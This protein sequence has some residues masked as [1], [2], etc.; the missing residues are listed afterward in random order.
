[1]ILLNSAVSAAIS[2][3]MDAYLSGSIISDFAVAHYSIFA[4]LADAKITNG[5]A[6]EFLREAK[7]RGADE[8]SNIYYNNFVDYSAEYPVT[9]PQVY[10]VGERELAF[11]SSVDYEKLRSGNYVIVSNDVI[12][13][14][15]NAVTVPQAGDTLT[16]T[17][18]N[19]ITQ[20]FEVYDSVDRYPFHLS[21]R[22]RFANCLTV[23]M[24][25]EVFSDFY[26]GTEPMQTNINVSAENISDFEIWLDGYTANQ[27]PDLDFISRNTLKTEFDGLRTTYLAL[28]GAMSLILAL[29]GV[30]NFI[31][32]VVASITARRRELAMLQSVGMTGKQTR[33]MLFSEGICY[34]ALTVVFTLTAGLGIGRLIVQGIAG[35]TWF[36]KPSFTVMPSIYCV[37]PLFAIC[38]V[39]PLVCYKRL[40]RE[41]LVERLR[42]E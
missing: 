15:D 21:A 2:F 4:N 7:A 37:V 25:S 9:G 29:I 19:G 10:G 5:V 8:I 26:G 39:V 33:S 32:A 14:G 28:G 18:D 13:Y 38:A 16:L 17:N 12:N 23:V 31:N 41:S 1:L 6:A 20:V 22:F 27:N 40:T 3:D 35:M 24:A 30:L 11:F 34:T 42:V 36:F